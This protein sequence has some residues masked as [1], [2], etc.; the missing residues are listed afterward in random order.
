MKWMN[1]YLN[2]F[3]FL[4]FN[5]SH[6]SP[7]VRLFFEEKKTLN[8]PVLKMLWKEDSEKLSLS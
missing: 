5:F 2:P 1:S 6:F 4:K 8:F 3:D 7:L